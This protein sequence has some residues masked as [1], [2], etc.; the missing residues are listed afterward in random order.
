MNRLVR[1]V[2]MVLLALCV[3]E[4]ADAQPWRGRRRKPGAG[5]DLAPTVAI[6]TPT[7]QPT[8]VTTATTINLEGIA[9]DDRGLANIRW[10][11]Q[12]T[13]ATGTATGTAAW[14]VTASAGTATT[15]QDQFGSATNENITAHTPNIGMAWTEAVDTGADDSCQILAATNSVGPSTNRQ[16]EFLVCLLEP[17]SALAGA[18]YTWPCQK[19]DTATA[20]SNYT[21]GCVFAYQDA[22]NFCSINWWGNANSVD[23]RL[24]RREGDVVTQIGSSQVDVPVNAVV[25]VDVDGTAITVSVDGVT[26]IGP[27]TSAFCGTVGDVGVMFGPPSASF[28]THW[29]R[30]TVRIDDVELIDRGASTSGIALNVGAN[31][32]EVCATDQ[33]TPTPHETCDLITV[34][35]AASDTTLP[36][37]SILD[38]SSGATTVAVE[39][40]SG[41]AS[42][43]IAV[44]VVTVSCPNCDNVAAVS[45]LAEWSVLVTLRCDGV[46]QNVISVTATDAALNVSQAD[47]ITRTC[48][49]A[50]ATAPTISITQPTSS[51]TYTAPSATINLGGTAADT[52]GSNVSQVT[53]T[54][55]RGGSGTASGTT[56]WTIPNLSLATG[57][58]VFTVRSQDGAGNLSTPDTLT[59]TLPVSDLSVVSASL[60]N[61]I[62]GS[63][64]EFCLVAQGGTPPYSWSKTAGSYPSGSPAFALNASTG[65][66]TGTPTGA[67]TQSGIAFQVTDS[68]GMPDTASVTGLSLQITA[69]GTGPDAFYTTLSARGDVYK[70]YNLRNQATIDTYSAMP[71]TVLTNPWVTYC[72][73]QPS[74]DSDPHRQNAAKVVVPFWGL[75]NSTLASS[76]TADLDYW[77][78][79][80]TQ[81]AG[82]ACI[83]INLVGTPSNYSPGRWLRIGSE[84][85]EVFDP[86]GTGPLNVRAT[87][88]GTPINGWHVRRAVNGTSAA[89]HASGSAFDLNSN[90]LLYQVKLPLG[91]TDGNTGSADGFTYY[92]TWDWMKTDSYLGQSQSGEKTWQFYCYIDTKGEGKICFEPQI[93]TAGSQSTAAVCSAFGT[94]TT[95]MSSATDVGFFQAR[96]YHQANTNATWSLTPGNQLG[97]NTI[98]SGSIICPMEQQYVLKPNVRYRFFFRIQQRANN[99]DLVDIWIA[100][101]TQDAVKVVENWEIS[102]DLN[103]NPSGQIGIRQW[104]IE[105]D[106]SDNAPAPN[107]IGDYHDYVNYAWWFVALRQAGEVAATTLTDAAL[108]SSGLLARPQ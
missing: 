12:T 40:I 104:F 62:V 30:D 97:P 29:Q 89:T 54:S 85:L 107:R 61:G 67:E 25:T 66:I 16:G 17:S 86:D 82:V 94:P 64:Y 74:C 5:S 44:S 75:S 19:A 3:A 7:A 99:F 52:G 69:A 27:I 22:Q 50:D 83:M 37:L 56:A 4:L 14:A 71:A 31:V 103:P 11:N 96:H 28:S 38:P 10:T 77:G 13:A 32:I 80:S 59:V 58:T 90:R 33:A 95:A 41:T 21:A 26:R 88:D 76:M 36:V 47:T 35:R 70:N 45:G 84:V 73:P 39:T 18:D 102:F 15:A 78:C 81:V 55:D 100:S 57:D 9:G 91:P 92:Y 23:M 63:A 65:C 105:I 106:S 51:A 20:A 87:V 8:F 101:E 2:A 79:A 49:T 108:A 98:R 60:P 68:A 24:F 93:V 72:S 6:Q 53:Y 34:T 48:T 43:N 42:D 1:V 46:T